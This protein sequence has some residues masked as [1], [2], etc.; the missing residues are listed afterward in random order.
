[1]IVD[2]LDSS[3]EIDESYV[4]ESSTEIHRQ[5]R[6]Y[7]RGERFT[8]DLEVTVPDGLTG[9]VMTAMA[10]IPYGET[11]T[12]GDLA[13]TLDTAPIAIGGACGRN[14]VPIVV[15]CH[16]VVG[17]D[18]GLRGYSG[19]AGISTKR[20]LLELEARYAP[21]LSTNEL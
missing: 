15:P 4:A 16:R 21:T 12:Y 11:R 2:I 1:M 14:P 17:H 8:F 7:E 19:G 18:G 6:E 13:E 5:L 3:I 9:R 20:E 10:A